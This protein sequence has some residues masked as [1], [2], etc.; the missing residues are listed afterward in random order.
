MWDFY[1]VYYFYSVRNLSICL[2][3]IGVILYIFVVSVMAFLFFSLRDT[4]YVQVKPETI[5]SSVWRLEFIQLQQV[6]LTLCQR[7]IFC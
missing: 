1:N 3:T 4:C 7:L 6:P 2:Y 5:V